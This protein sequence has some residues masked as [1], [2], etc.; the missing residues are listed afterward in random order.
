MKSKRMLK[1]A[2]VVSA[3]ALLARG[4]YFLFHNG[5]AQK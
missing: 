1:M 2:A 3:A 5:I 4:V